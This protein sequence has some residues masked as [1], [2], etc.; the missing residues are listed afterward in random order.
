MNENKKNIVPIAIAH[1]DFKE[2]FG[3]PR[4]SGRC[5]SV[6][7]KILFEKPFNSIDFIR[8][9]ENFSH[10][11]LI[12]GFSLCNREKFS[13]TVRPPRLGGNTHIGVFASRAPYR[14]NG[15]GLSCVKLEKVIATDVET[16]L[17][18]SGLDLLDGTPIY[19]I[20][21][22]I[23]NTDSI[24]SATGGYADNFSSYHLQ[25]VMP[26]NIEKS[27]PQKIYTAIKECLAE[28]PR[29]A[30]HIDGRIYGMKFAEYEIKFFVKNDTLTVT[31]IVKSL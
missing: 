7:G 17:L 25:V 6:V 24:L 26:D 9:I 13:A 31:D 11:W 4:Q 20:K 19:D 16:A 22:Y 15:L 27:I 14:P 21:P 29:P 1:T 28:D 5:P 10:L 12:F 2:K 23:P 18:V 3:I 30:Y 8:G